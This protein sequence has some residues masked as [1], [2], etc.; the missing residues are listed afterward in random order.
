[1]IDPRNTRHRPELVDPAAFIA[2]GAVVLGDVTIGAESSVWFGAVIRGDSEAIRIGSQTNVQDGCVL[3]VDEGVPCTLGDRVTL[4][5]GAIERIHELENE[6]GRSAAAG[7]RIGGDPGAS[8]NLLRHV[9]AELASGVW[10]D[11]VSIGIA[12][13]S[14]VETQ[15]LV[16]LGTGRITA[17]DSIADALDSAGRWIT[18][19]N[20]RMSGL[21]IADVLSG[22][23]TSTP[24]EA[25]RLSPYAL[26]LAGPDTQDLERL[27][28]LDAYLAGLG[29]GRVA[30]AATTD[31]KVGRHPITV[32]A[33]H[34]VTMEFLDPQGK[35]IRTFTGTTADAERK[36]DV[37]A[38]LDDPQRARPCVY[39]A[40][41][42]EALNLG[43]THE[44]SSSG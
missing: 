23:V 30:V 31:Q 5:H 27:A 8:A 28:R 38:F 18:G 6:T 40:I 25:A 41:R 11:G 17:A 35:A 32:D 42:C 14:A 26:L 1:V 22:R 29:R 21:G 20:E 39:S 19:A 15:Q 37:G 2:P 36:P 16:A 43:R 4:G 33:D 7:I 12:G 13:F 9:G 34:Q 24:T 44:N 10:S 3:H